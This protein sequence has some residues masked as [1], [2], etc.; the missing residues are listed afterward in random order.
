MPARTGAQGTRGYQDL[1]DARRH[2]VAVAALPVDLVS[3]KPH[4]MDDSEVQLHGK[5]YRIG[6]PEVP[7]ATSAHVQELARCTRMSRC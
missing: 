1:Q 3:F 5:S 7:S 2:R 6:A 4:G